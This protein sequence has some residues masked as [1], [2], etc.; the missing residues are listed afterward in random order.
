LG[1]EP[2]PAENNQAIDLG[3]ERTKISAI[4][5]GEVAVGKE[6][7]ATSSESAPSTQAQYTDE[8]L[9]PVATI[10]QP[11]QTEPVPTAE[12]AVRIVTANAEATRNERVAQVAIDLERGGYALAA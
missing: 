11:K 10:E 9:A 1:F 3:Q 4:F 8:V 12:E 7:Q 2:V 6:T 5:G